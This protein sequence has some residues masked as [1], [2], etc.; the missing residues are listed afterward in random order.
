MAGNKD[1]EKIVEAMRLASTPEARIARGKTPRER[2][3]LT[4][5]EALYGEGTRAARYQAYEAAMARVQERYPDDLD[6]A[7]LHALALLAIRP[8]STKNG[9]PGGWGKPNV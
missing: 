3:Y 8:R 2:A 5:A 7:A 4:A 9:F 6:A 1:F